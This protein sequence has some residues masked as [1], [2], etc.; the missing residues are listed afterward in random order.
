[1]SCFKPKQ[2]ISSFFLSPN[3]TSIFLTTNSSLWTIFTTGLKFWAACSQSVCVPVHVHSPQKSGCKRVHFFPL[4][5]KRHQCNQSAALSLP[6]LQ[7]K[8]RSLSRAHFISAK[9]HVMQGEAVQTFPARP[10]RLTKR[11]TSYI[12]PQLQ[13]WLMELLPWAGKKKSRYVFTATYQGYHC[14]LIV[15]FVS[16]RCHKDY[17]WT[18]L[19]KSKVHNSA[20]PCLFMAIKYAWALWVYIEYI[21][22]SPLH[23]K[24]AI[25]SLCVGFNVKYNIQMQ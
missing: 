12:V 1:M 8:P 17:L 15:L 24:L 13:N 3:S 7:Y 23:W 11:S 22:R 14:I 25:S 16:K 10:N 9:S 20:Q 19:P 2:T 4:S 21:H 5:T 18:L 6:W